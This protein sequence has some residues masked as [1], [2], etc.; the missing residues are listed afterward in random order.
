MSNTLIL[1][2]K[3]LSQNKINKINS[4]LSRLEDEFFN[5]SENI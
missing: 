2:S 5:S 1:N 4:L 3:H